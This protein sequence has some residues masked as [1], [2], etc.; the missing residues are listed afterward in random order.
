MKIKKGFVLRKVAGQHVVI[1]IGEATRSLSGMIRLNETGAF[2]WG[3]LEKGA[4]MDNLLSRLLEEY[5]VSK[6]TAQRD[7]KE[8]VRVL[9]EAGCLE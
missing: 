4:D 7:V 9:T 1:A 2:L 3:E 6:D 5:D 8:F